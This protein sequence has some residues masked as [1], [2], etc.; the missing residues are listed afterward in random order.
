MRS[1]LVLL[2]L[3]VLVYPI[4]A[5]GEDGI[6]VKKSAKEENSREVYVTDGYQEMRFQDLTFLLF[7][8][9]PHAKRIEVLE[10]ERTWKDYTRTPYEW[11]G[12]LGANT[13]DDQDWLYIT[14]LLEDDQGVRTIECRATLFKSSITL[15]LHNCEDDRGTDMES[16]IG[17]ELDEI[18]IEEEN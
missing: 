18:L 4:F 13:H 2:F 8:K 11:I 17:I 3:I 12:L 6:V 15:G 16:F 9:F 14:W 5:E 1:L 7:K 10:L